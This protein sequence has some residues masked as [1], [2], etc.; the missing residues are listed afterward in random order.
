MMS[1][2][3]K[4]AA[5]YSNTKTKD[6]ETKRQELKAAKKEEPQ[7]DVAMSKKGGKALQH[8]DKRRQN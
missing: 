6:G 8:Q 7:D 5:K 2:S 1:R 4:R 3:V